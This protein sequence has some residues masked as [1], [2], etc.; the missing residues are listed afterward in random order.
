[1]S[2]KLLPSSDAVHEVQVN[3]GPVRK[4][5]NGAIEVTESEAKVLRA[6]GDF[7]TVGTHFQG[8]DGHECP[9][10]GRM[11]VF[12]DSCGRCGWKA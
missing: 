2:V 8:V 1:M 3:R 10:C 4:R 7:G 6:S 5:K 9:Q 12:K 11:N